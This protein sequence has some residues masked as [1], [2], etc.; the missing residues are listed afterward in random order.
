M[1][2]IDEE[3]DVNDDQC[4]YTKIVP[5]DDL[6]TDI[7]AKIVDHADAAGR[8]PFQSQAR[9][10]YVL[11]TVFKNYIRYTPFQSRSAEDYNT[12]FSSVLTFFKLHGQK[13]HIIRMDNEAAQQSSLLKA[14]FVSADVTVEYVAPGD[15]RTLLAERAIRTAN[16][17]HVI[18]ILAGADKLYPQAS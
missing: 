7:Q 10:N 6:N 18:S 2:T 14:A 5:F 9:N 15:H 8:F 1:P 3:D 11:I 13:L 17:N 4:L 16:K 12:A